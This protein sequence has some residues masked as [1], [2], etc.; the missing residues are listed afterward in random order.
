MVKSISCDSGVTRPQSDVYK[1]HQ[2]W[3]R[4]LD[5]F[6]SMIPES[7]E[8]RESGEKS[9]KVETFRTECI[10]YSLACKGPVMLQ[11][12][13]PELL[14]APSKHTSLAVPKDQ[15]DHSITSVSSG[16]S[17]EFN[18]TD[19]WDELYQ[20]R[21]EKDWKEEEYNELCPVS[22]DSIMTSDTSNKVTKHQEQSRKLGCLAQ[23]DT[24]LSLPHSE[25]EDSTFGL[26]SIPRQ[27]LIKST[28]CSHA[29]EV[30]CLSA[31]G[32]ILKEITAQEQ[33]YEHLRS[34]LSKQLNEPLLE[35]REDSADTEGRKGQR[36]K[37]QG[38]SLTFTSSISC[39]AGP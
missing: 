37:S 34:S 7:T 22:S 33:A 39:G 15:H 6:M 25:A 27:R 9:K 13:I 5:D 24:V 2:L 20:D 4:S 32:V 18:K 38:L 36:A 1:Q 31:P 16:S 23:L 21:P 26:N 3:S 28:S 30:S 11:Q 17:S 10:Q 14:V 35:Y 8:L 29:Q 12:S 19:V